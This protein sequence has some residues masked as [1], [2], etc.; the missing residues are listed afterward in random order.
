MGYIRVSKANCKNCYRCLK[1][2]IIKSISVKEEKVTVIEDMCILCG[3][4]VATCPQ[5]AMHA[6]AD[7][8]K[9][10]EYLKNP[11]ITTVASLAPSFIAA[12][13]DNYKKAVSALRH[14]GF[15]HVEETSVGALYV[16]NGY[17]RLIEEN[18][19]EN[20]LTSCCPSINMLVTK[21]Y[22]ELTRFL[23]PVMSPVLVHGKLIKQKYGDDAKVCFIGPCLAK[24]KE[25]NDNSNYVD[26]AVSFDQVFRWFENEKINIA[27]LEEC[28][29]ENESSF[30]RIYPIH[31]GIEADLKNMFGEY[32]FTEKTGEYDILSL[33][34]I[35]EV[36]QLLEDIRA[37]KVKKVFA[38]VNACRGGCINGPLM[39]EK[40]QNSYK[41]RIDVKN[42]AKKAQRTK[43]KYTDIDMAFVPERLEQNMPTEEEI[44][45]ILYQIGKYT[46]EQELNCGSC[47]YPT[48]REKA[49]AVYQKKAELYMCLPYMNDI[50]QTMSNVTLSVTP[51]Y[52]I[53]VDEGMTIKEFNVAAQKLFKVS[54]NEAVG[55]TLDRFIDAKDFETVI[56]TKKSIFG[57]KV[58]Y[59]ELGIITSQDII[60]A[61][62][63]N[64][65]VAIFY[66]ITDEE[67]KKELARSLKLESVEMAQRVIDKQMTV[68][69]QI[70]SLLGETTA[71]TKVTL[72]KLK[73]LIASEE[74][75][76]DE[77]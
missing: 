33:G 5:K 59:D 52:I 37:G 57:K 73:N 12:F 63:R 1:N 61:E 71:E 9:V 4:C 46:K 23:A 44:R 50:N 56:K 36:R 67:N 49:I 30:S 2:C 26:A 18:K 53:A 15:D 42:Y 41:D 75:D 58:K 40:K 45:R 31:N 8:V 10:M 16:T 20:I 38:E 62:N 60:Y 74:T 68:A 13:G 65:A 6:Q 39:P 43:I 25:I 34:G 29:F 54:R 66:D 24:I 32:R 70:A 28:E 47:G 64:M 7:S 27:S 3:Q 21:Y 51:N 11:N 72:N 17:K 55:K 77:Q 76:S 14:L 48:C 35:K 69:Q 22:P 19:M